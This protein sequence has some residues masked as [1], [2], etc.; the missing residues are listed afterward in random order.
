MAHAATIQRTGTIDAVITGVVVEG[1]VA[2]EHA[3]VGIGVK[4]SNADKADRINLTQEQTRV[5]LDLYRL[6]L[7]HQLEGH[8]VQAIYQKGE[9]VRI[10]PPSPDWQ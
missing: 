10:E 9:L 2:P 8:F 7:P 4:P 1:E 6:S 3:L 5:L